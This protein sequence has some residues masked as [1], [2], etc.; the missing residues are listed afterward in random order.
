MFLRNGQCL[1]L[2]QQSSEAA[3][4]LAST[5][6]TVL[7]PLYGEPFIIDI[8]RLHDIQ[9]LGPEDVAVSIKRADG[10]TDLLICLEDPSEGI[11]AAGVVLQ[12][13]IGLCTI[14]ADFA[15][16]HRLAQHSLT[17]IVVSRDILP[18][19]ESQQMVAVLAVVAAPATRACNCWMRACC[20]R[21][22]SISS[23]FESWC[24]S[25]RGTATAPGAMNAAGVASSIQDSRGPEKS[26]PILDNVARRGSIICTTTCPSLRPFGPCGPWNREAE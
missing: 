21:M 2:N 6:V 4:D 24:S 19:E 20:R 13:R 3:G 14:A 9:G 15:M 23:D 11:T 26:R 7:E 16:H 10:A 5:F 17:G 1:P 25:S 22:I 8:E 18:R 12:G